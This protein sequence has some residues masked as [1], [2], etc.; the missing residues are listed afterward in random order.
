MSED[1]E[2]RWTEGGSVSGKCSYFVPRHHVQIGFWAHASAIKWSQQ[3]FLLEQGDQSACC[4]FL[5]LVQ[6]H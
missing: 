5:L 1:S 3:L 4:H 2:S 6:V